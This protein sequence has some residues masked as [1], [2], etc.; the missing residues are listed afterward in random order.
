MPCNLS[1]ILC[2]MLCILSFNGFADSDAATLKEEALQI[3][4]ENSKKSVAP[5]EYASC[6]LKLE[7]AM[8]ILDKA[9]D[10]D[11]PLAQEV[12]SSLFWARKFSNSQVIK[13]LEKLKASDGTPLASSK[14]QTPLSK[15][16]TKPN[17]PASI[18]PPELIAARAAQKAFDA[19]ETFVNSHK[20]DDYAVSLRWFQMANQY[21]G[22]DSGLKALERARQAQLRFA[23]KNGAAAKEEMPDTPEMEL[24]K[25][26]DELAAAQKFEASF[27]LYKKS[28]KMKESIIAHR[29]FANAS[30]KRAQQ[31]NDEVKP[32]F[33]AHYAKYAQAYQGAWRT[34]SF[35]RRFEP[36]DAGLKAWQRQLADLKKESDVAQRYYQQAEQ[37]NK[38]IL[39]MSPE[40]KDFEA[41]GY[42][43]LCQSVRP[44]FKGTGRQTL[45]EFVKSYTPENDAERSLYE[46]CKTEIERLTKF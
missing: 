29:R 21:P 42:L 20:D 5:E 27:D 10:T 3:L 13:A 40:Q 17:D 24:V 33:E 39:R 44:F 41:A 12:S 1:R 28:L 14:V 37:E 31:I 36:D 23:A 6:L 18:E 35:G 34:T 30:F 8:S 11:S 9:G 19:A 46:F 45:M 4:K 7:K 22:T 43:G 38:A 16:V 25:S 32:K 2:C 15:S 26:G